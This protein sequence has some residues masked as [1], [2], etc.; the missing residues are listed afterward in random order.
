MITSGIK[1]LLK[2]SGL[3]FDDLFGND[4]KHLIDFG[5]K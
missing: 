2:D 3:V 1:V 5:E 4:D